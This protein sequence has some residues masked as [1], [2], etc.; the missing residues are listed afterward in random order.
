MEPVCIREGRWGSRWGWE[1][2][3]KGRLALPGPTDQK[4]PL[5]GA[6]LLM[7]L[8]PKTTSIDLQ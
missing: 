5:P 6:V 3:T 1:E 7:C 8:D 2:G 4:W